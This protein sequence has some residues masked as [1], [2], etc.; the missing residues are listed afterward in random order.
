MNGPAGNGLFLA[1]HFQNAY[2]TRDIDAAA[3]M[4]ASRHGILSF[5]YMRDIPFGPGATIHIGL[6]WAGD[7]M[8]ELIQPGGDAANLYS[9]MLPPDGQ[10]VR[11]HHLGH[12]LDRRDDWDV[13]VGRAEKS[14]MPVVLHGNNHGINYLYLDARG[15]TGHY[16]EY[17]HL[18]PEA[19][20][21]FKQAPR[22]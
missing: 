18:D 8:V 19:A 3:A 10:L 20:E 14:G 17:V 11:F 4:F 21:F 6:A 1:R 7:V 5:H 16:L 13:V 12:L 15:D 2:V 9:T 22:Y